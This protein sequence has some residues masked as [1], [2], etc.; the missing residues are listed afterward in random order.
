V[1]TPLSLL[2]EQYAEI[3]RSL[4]V[5]VRTLQE[6][7]TLLAKLARQAKER[8]WPAVREHEAAAEAAHHAEQAKSFLLRLRAAQSE[9]EVEGWEGAGSQGSGTARGSASTRQ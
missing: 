2:E 3:E 1:L 7:A 4:W 6:R 8:G 9:A 5:A